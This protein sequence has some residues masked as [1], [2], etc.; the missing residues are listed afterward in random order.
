[1]DCYFEQVIVHDSRKTHELVTV[2]MWNVLQN[3]WIRRA[4]PS[5][6]LDRFVD[7]SALV[8]LDV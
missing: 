2:W 1:M 5:E 8:F 7:V 4:G 3:Y 6:Q